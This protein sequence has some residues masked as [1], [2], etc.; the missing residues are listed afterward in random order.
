MSSQPYD[1]TVFTMDSRKNLLSSEINQFNGFQNSITNDISPDNNSQ[2]NINEYIQH[3]NSD[4]LY[5]PTHQRT[6]G[7]AIPDIFMKR[8]SQLIETNR[9]GGNDWIGI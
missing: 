8:Q 6:I 7:S 4:P 1:P 5:K 2:V 9:S 3:M